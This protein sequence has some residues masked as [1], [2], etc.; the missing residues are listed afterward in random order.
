LICGQ[1]SRCQAAQ[2]TQ[3]TEAYSTRVTLAPSA[4]PLAMSPWAAPAPPPEL[5]ADRA[6]A[7]SAAPVMAARR[8]MAAKRKEVR[9]A[10]MAEFP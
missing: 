8:L 6:M 5:Q 7:A 1:T 4:A 9:E 3:V 10:D 2:P